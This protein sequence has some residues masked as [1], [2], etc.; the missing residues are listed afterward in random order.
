VHNALESPCVD[1][2]DE[3]AEREGYEQRRQYIRQG[4]GRR[5]IQKTEVK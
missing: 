1:K 4:K 3:Q 2:K 5:L